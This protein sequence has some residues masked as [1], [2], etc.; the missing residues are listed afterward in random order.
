MSR[1]NVMRLSVLDLSP[2]P[3]GF[4]AAQALHNTL[5]LA[6]HTDQLGYMRYWLSEHHNT[7]LLASSSPEILIGHVASVTQNMRIGSG[8]IM[9]PNHAPL[10][11]A[12]M[13]RTLEALHPGRIDLGLGRAPGT[14]PRTAL[15]LRRSRE[16]NA[17]NFPLQLEELLGFFYGTLPDE[18]P[19]RRITAIPE[20]VPAPEVWL[21]GSSD[22]SALL[23][24]QMGLGFAFAHH[25]S[26]APAVAALRLYR[27]RFQPSSYLQAPQALLATGVICAPTDEEAEELAG[28][29][30]LAWLGLHR[31]PQ[32]QRTPL[33][34]V[35]EAKAYEYAPHERDLVRVNRERLFVGAP[36]TVREQLLRLAEAAGVTEIMAMTMIHDHQKRRRSYELLAE[37]FAS[38]A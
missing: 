28:S 23:A 30:D 18:H 33:P 14:D 16:V 31:I 9:L 2:V 17:D 5:D 11:V 13:F 34:S 8:G 38:G 32:N 19:L 21:L 27:E 24:A 20:G 15:A 29:A 26:P 37:A 12:E 1:T 22:F 35:E 36:A 4:S 25:I 7:S 3:S 6:Q 10:K